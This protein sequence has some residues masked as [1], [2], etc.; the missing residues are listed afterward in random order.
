MA[1]HTDTQP[2]RADSAAYPGIPWLRGRVPV[3]PTVPGGCAARNRG[4][5]YVEHLVPS[6]R[7]GTR[8]STGHREPH[9]Q[10]AF[11]CTAPGAGQHRDWCLPRRKRRAHALC[12]SPALCSR[13]PVGPRYLDMDLLKDQELEEQLEAAIA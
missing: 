3:M 2:R 5:D 9:N 8:N 11:A 10:T 13:I 12:C 7:A 4:A 1:M 6:L